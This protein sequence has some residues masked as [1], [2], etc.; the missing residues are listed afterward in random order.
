MVGCGAEAGDAYDYWGLND[1]A[2][3]NK[4]IMVYPESNCWDNSG[5]YDSEYHLTKYGLYPETIMNMISALTE[6]DFEKPSES[7]LNFAILGYQMT[8]IGVL[9]AYL[10]F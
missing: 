5:G 10:F 9:T 4:L 6:E 8:A 3:T 7:A 2:S 1:L